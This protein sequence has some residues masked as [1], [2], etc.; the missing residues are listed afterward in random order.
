MSKIQKEL[1]DSDRMPF[2]KYK[3]T[4]M[5]NVPADYLLWLSEQDLSCHEELRRYIK[6]VKEVLLMEKKI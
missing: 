3:D 4:L 6:A 2:G 1:K 5:C